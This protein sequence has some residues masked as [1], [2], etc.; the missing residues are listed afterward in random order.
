MAKSAKTAGPLGKVNQFRSVLSIIKEMS[1]DEIR[2]DAER[3][4]RILLL[5][6][7]PAGAGL[8]EE[9]TGTPPNASAT[10]ERLDRVPKNIERYD[11]I[12][13]HASGP[14]TPYKQIRDRAGLRSDRVFDLSTTSN[15]DWAQRT[16][17]MIVDHAT[18]RA[19]ALARY[20]ALRT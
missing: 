5:S 7:D 15:P 13:V 17:Q 10:V 19:E 18:E 2:D 14:S 4:P 12:L 20:E 16:R 8:I 6:D 11:I 9:L 3:M 1:L